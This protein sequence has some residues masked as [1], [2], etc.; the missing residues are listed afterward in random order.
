MKVP[1]A[2]LAA[3]ASNWV[4]VLVL[5]SPITTIFSIFWF[6]VYWNLV[7]P[8][9]MNTTSL[10]I[11]HHR[12]LLTFSLHAIY[13]RLSSATS[14]I[15]WHRVLFLKILATL[16]FKDLKGLSWLF[17]LLYFKV[18]AYTSFQNVFFSLCANLNNTSIVWLCSVQTNCCSIK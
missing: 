18:H 5:A 2:A 1:A 9:W 10:T 16:F 17:H 12:S 11:I 14:T 7:T 13:N 3:V 15:I 4:V 6:Y 8:V